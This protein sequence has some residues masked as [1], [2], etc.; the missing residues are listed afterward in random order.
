MVEL[1]LSMCEGLGSIPSTSTEKK[2]CELSTE[3]TQA[4]TKREVA[5]ELIFRGP[6]KGS[7]SATAVGKLAEGW[8]SCSLLQLCYEH[9]L[10]SKQSLFSDC[11]HFRCQSGYMGRHS[12]PAPP[13]HAPNFC[14]S[15]ATTFNSFV[16]FWSYISESRYSAH[17]APFFSVRYYPLPSYDRKWGLSSLLLR[18]IYLFFPHSPNSFIPFFIKSALEVTLLWPDKLWFTAKPW[19][20]VVCG[21]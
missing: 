7:S 3:H 14:C 6:E 20:L 11:A 15:D 8:S 1:Q 16:Y 18:P 21:D 12:G 13:L 2:K 9:S 19:G 5:W 4:L 10:C 17:M